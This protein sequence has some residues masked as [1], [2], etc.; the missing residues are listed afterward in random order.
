MESNDLQK[1]LLGLIGKPVKELVHVDFCEKLKGLGL[2]TH[3]PTE[4]CCRSLRGCI[5]H[6]HFFVLGCRGLA[7]DECCA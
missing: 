7:F 5:Q 2:D 6:M 1:A 3:L 4:V